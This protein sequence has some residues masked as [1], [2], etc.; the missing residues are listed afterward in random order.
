VSLASLLGRKTMQ[1]TKHGAWPVVAV[2]SRATALTFCRLL[3]LA[4]EPYVPDDVR[5]RRAF[6]FTAELGRSCSR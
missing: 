5:V 2:Q 6:R 1:S 3:F 4:M